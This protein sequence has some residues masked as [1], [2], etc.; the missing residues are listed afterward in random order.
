MTSKEAIRKTMELCNLAIG[1]NN[2]D[3]SGG[4]FWNQQFVPREYEKQ[5]TK[6]TILR[7][8][9]QFNTPFSQETLPANMCL[10]TAIIPAVPQRFKYFT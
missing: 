10:N 3:I 8:K 7:K 1:T 2:T 6:S 5:S 9:S 4:Q